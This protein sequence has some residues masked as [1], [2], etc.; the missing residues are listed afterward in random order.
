[1]SKPV[2]PLAL[3][4]YRSNTALIRSYAALPG[5]T[6]NPEKEQKFLQGKLQPDPDAV[7]TQSSI[8]PIIGEVGEQEQEQDV[9]MM[10]GV[11][12][13]IVRPAQSPK[14]GT[15]MVLGDLVQYHLAV[16]PAD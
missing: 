15:F 4:A 16:D 9:D 14:S 8:H 11:R 5:T 12:H 10:S 13:D 1:M 6:R 7:T 3:T 2:R